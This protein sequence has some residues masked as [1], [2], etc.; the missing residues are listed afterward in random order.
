MENLLEFM[1]LNIIV[2]WIEGKRERNMKIKEIYE[3]LDDF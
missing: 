2:S 3:A 1:M